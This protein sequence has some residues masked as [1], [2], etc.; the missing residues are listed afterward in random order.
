M[1]AGLSVSDVVRKFYVYCL[2]RPDGTP[3]YIGKGSGTRIADH[4]KTCR[5]DGSHK[6]NIIAAALAAGTEIPA[7]KLVGGLTEDAAFEIE[8]AFIKAIGREPHGPLVNKT[9]GGEG[10]SGRTFSEKTRRQMSETKRG[11]PSPRKGAVLSES[12]RE[13]LRNAHI[14]RPSPNKGREMSEEQKAKLRASHK[15]KSLSIEH[16]QKITL[17]LKANPP[18]KGRV[19]SDEWRSNMRAA[20]LA[21]GQRAAVNGD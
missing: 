8:K 19:F 7:V 4:Y 10:P 16:R 12:T 14:G 2:F 11:R 5:H 17:S 21:R 6:A 1:A 20:H 3:F 15:G 13:K 18:N 9:D